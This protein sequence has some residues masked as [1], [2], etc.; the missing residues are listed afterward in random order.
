[1][2]A[3]KVP[4]T[5]DDASRWMT[6]DRPSSRQRHLSATVDR[7]TGCLERGVNTIVARRAVI[8][9]IIINRSVLPIQYPHTEHSFFNEKYIES[10]CKTRISSEY[11]TF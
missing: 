1:V 5:D 11:F 9:I 8:I 4:E 10:K 6:V 7:L 2:T 3:T